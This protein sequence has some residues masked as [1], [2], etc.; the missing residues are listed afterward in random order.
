[1]PPAEFLAR[2]RGSGGGWAVV[3]LK[4]GPP[5]IPINA[6]RS[7][8]VISQRVCPPGGCPLPNDSSP[9]AWRPD[10]AHPGYFY[11]FRGDRQVGAWHPNELGYRELRGDG[12]WASAALPM[13]LPI[14]GS[15]FGLDVAKVSSESRY[16]RNGREIT[17]GEAFAAV[18]KLV[19]DSR[20]RRLTIVG[21]EAFRA[22]VRGDLARDE[23]LRAWTTQLLVQDYPP[24]H[25]AVAGVGM[26]PG[27]TLQGPPDADG[28]APVLCRMSQ[29]AG[30]DDLVGA[31]RRADPEYRPDRDPEPN[32]PVE[33]RSFPAVAWILIGAT[34]LL[35]L[36]PRKAKS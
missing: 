24:D 26:A 30:P 35:F 12:S 6:P 16:R 29:Y 27:V 32:A 20:H 14:A 36:L 21:D 15:N 31:L 9:L 25:W 33:P 4:P 17:R 19:D 1:M 13:P 28:K 8:D 11:L 23:R 7:T 2:W 3:L 5:P 10:L 22:Q 34:I 18:A